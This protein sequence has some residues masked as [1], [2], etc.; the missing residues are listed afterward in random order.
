MESQKA[1]KPV[2]N[3]YTQLSI[4]K[5]FEAVTSHA[6]DRIGAIHRE[7]TLSEQF[8]GYD[9]LLADGTK[10]ECKLDT[11]ASKNGR[12]F[13]ELTQGKTLGCIFTTGADI[14]LFSTGLKVYSFTP[15]YLREW[16]AAHSESLKLLTVSTGSTGVTYPL[17][18]DDLHCDIEQLPQFLE[19]LLRNC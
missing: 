11:Y 6:L 4:G 18:P 2:Y 8:K 15:K 19:E 17:Q 1:L 13:L 10:I 7:A 5:G 3:F 14:I 16:F 12:I 9:F